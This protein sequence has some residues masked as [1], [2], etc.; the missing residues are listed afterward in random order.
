MKQMLAVLSPKECCNLLNGDLSV[1]IR[2]VKP[3]CKLPIIVNVYCSKKG[4]PLVYGSP[5][6][7]YVE[8]KYVQTYGWSKEDADKIFGNLQG[9]VVAKFTLNKVEEIQYS[10]EKRQYFSESLSEKDLLSKSCLTDV[11]LFQYLLFREVGYTWHIDNL[12]IFNQPKE[13]SEFEHQVI[14]ENVYTNEK[15]YL[16]EPLRKAPKTFCYIEV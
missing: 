3:N 5:I 11:E 12:E 8:E 16:R 15:R 4:R 1:L 7:S 9:K 14:Y 2:K 10:H 13:I 6:P